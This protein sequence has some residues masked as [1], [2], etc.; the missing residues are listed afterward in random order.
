[1]SI[2]HLMPEDL[3]GYDHGAA[4]A[5]ADRADMEN[6]EAWIQRKHHAGPEARAA[7][8]V[9]VQVSVTDNLISGL[10]KAYHMSQGNLDAAADLELQALILQLRVTRLR[11]QMAE[12]P[13]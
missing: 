7:L 13:A 6:D 8:P 4:D 2:D 9:T 1:M 5:A 3:K 10:Q 11:Q 12:R